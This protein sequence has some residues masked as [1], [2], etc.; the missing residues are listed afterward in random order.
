VECRYVDQANGIN[1]QPSAVLTSQNP[2]VDW[3]LFMCDLT[4]RNFDYRL[5]YHMASGGTSVTAWTTTNA[6]KID[7]VDPFP[8]KVT[9]M[10]LAALDWTQFQQALVFVAYPRKDKPA[11]QQSFTLTKNAATAPAFVVERQDPTQTLIYYEARLIRNN[12]QVWTIPGSVTSDPY[13]ILQDGMKGHQIISVVPEQVDF[14]GKHISQINVQL[15]YVD[16]ANSL[17]IS[18]S[19]SITNATDVR[20]FAYDFLSAQ[21]SP[22]Y[23]ADIQLDNGQTKSV[24]WTPISGNVLTIPL[25]Q[26]D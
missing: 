25:S 24:D 19:V 18:Q 14:S 2:E 11:L 7:I 15:R 1:L 3:A 13:L 8:T 17:N 23:R 21:I 22:E 12:G 26:F 9:L 10:V 6:S 16:Q 20:T 5:T 4:R